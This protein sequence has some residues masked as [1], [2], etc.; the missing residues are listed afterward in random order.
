MNLVCI[1]QVSD[2]ATKLIDFDV[3]D[4]AIKM[5]D[6]DAS[7]KHGEACHLKFSSSSAPPM[8]ASELLEYELMT[9]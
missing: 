7:A 1:K 9:G 4:T 8:L 6:F 2:T 3:S 5:I